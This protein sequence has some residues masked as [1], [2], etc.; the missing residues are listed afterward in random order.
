MDVPHDCDGIK[1]GL[2]VSPVA[3]WASPG[4]T[5]ALHVNGKFE[6]SIEDEI[7]D[8]IQ[9]D[10]FPMNLAAGDNVELFASNAGAT[11]A[12]VAAVMSTAF[13]GAA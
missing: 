1:I 10:F 5:F 6:Q 9:R 12:I 7:A 13:E 3:A 11:D 2:G 4:I 8:L